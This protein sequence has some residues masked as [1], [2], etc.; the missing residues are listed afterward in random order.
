MPAFNQRS[1]TNFYNNRPFQ[2]NNNNFNKSFGLQTNIKP[3]NG[4]NVQNGSQ[5]NQLPIKMVKNLLMQQ[6][7]TYDGLIIIGETGS[8]KTTQTPQYIYEMFKDTN[9]QC[10]GIT[11]P[12]RVAAVSLA[13][14]VADEMF[15][16][17]GDIV[18]YKIRFDDT[19]TSNTKIK[20]M[21]D[22]ILLREAITD[23]YLSNY[24]VIILDE[25]HERTIQTDIL[26]G[27]VKRAQRLRSLKRQLESK[28]GFSPLKIII[29]SATVDV[30]NFSMYFGNIPVFYIVGRNH[31]IKIFYTKNEQTDYTK[32]ALTTVFQIHQDVDEL[33][34]DSSIGGDI[35]VFCT[36][37]EEIESMIKTVNNSANVFNKLKTVRGNFKTLKAYPLYSALPTNIQQRI[38]TR[39][40]DDCF[41]RVIFAT[42]IAETS[43]TIPN[44]RF[45]ID[46]GKVKTKRFSSLCG[47]ETM[48]IETISKAQA[49][50]RTGRAGRLSSGI[51]YRLY[52][53]EE[54]SNFATFPEPEIKKC[55]LSSIILNLIALEI[56]NIDNFEFIDAPLK[57]NIQSALFNLIK[58]GAIFQVKNL[59]YH[60][61]PKGKIMVLFPIEPRFSLLITMSEKYRCTEEIIT[62]IAMLSVDNIFFVPNDQQD[63]AIAMHKKFSTSE[64][65]LI[66]L[67]NIFRRFKEAKQSKEWCQEHFLRQVQLKNAFEIRQQLIELCR[68]FYIPVTN[69]SNTETIRKCLTIGSGIGIG[70]G[71]NIAFLQ[72]DG[73]YLTKPLNSSLPQTAFIHPSSCLFQNNPECVL[74]V[75]MVQTN[76]F[77]M[78]NV[79]LIDKRWIE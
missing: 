49:C 79:C 9:I 21:T 1:K 77:Y 53:E 40:N 76:K 13:K 55:N 46:T 65:D 69:C 71:A 36:G 34:N 78:R 64:G 70:L 59:D 63:Q 23:P 19:T 39:N 15:T 28:S 12:R 22:G 74:F 27:I 6:I 26:F 51:C 52:T 29:M 75:E 67:L 8:G 30:D 37:Q 4:T 32:A 5:T 24:S 38:F 60:L 73:S 41:R 18:G 62:I 50:Q 58:M 2:R 3:F 54:Y 45:V 31:P 61:T 11:Q 43:I 7:N 47:F 33:S 68:K 66:K 42:N 57:E 56:N 48:T 16:K 20:F 72:R 14:R 25:V 44:I 10:I 17:L 35:L